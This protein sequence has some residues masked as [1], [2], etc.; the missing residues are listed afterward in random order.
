M[1]MLV[2]KLATAVLIKTDEQ[3]S[4]QIRNVNSETEDLIQMLSLQAITQS[5]IRLTADNFE[6]Y[7][8]TN[9]FDQKT[10]FLNISVSLE[11]EFSN[12]FIKKKSIFNLIKNAQEFDLLCR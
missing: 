8:K 10:V 9:N 6:S 1:S 7:K 11:T 2:N 5:K 3:Y 12:F 4:C